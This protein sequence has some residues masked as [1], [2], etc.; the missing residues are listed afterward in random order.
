MNKAKFMEHYVVT[1]LI[2]VDGF[3]QSNMMCI[4]NIE[5]LVTILILVDGFLQS[6]I[7]E[8]KNG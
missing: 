6:I 4:L 3:L 2:L 5:N 7:L 1:I 8:L